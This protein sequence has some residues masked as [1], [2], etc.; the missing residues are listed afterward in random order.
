MIQKPIREYPNLNFAA[1]ILGYMSKIGSELETLAEKGYTGQ[2]MIGKSGIEATMEQYLKGQNGSR[3]IEIDVA[4]S[5]I[6]TVSEEEPTP[7]D[8]VFL[9]IDYT[10]QK[11]LKTL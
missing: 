10:L 5:M 8:T 11:L 6:D 9:T 7:G 4:G 1:H 3:Q 2:D